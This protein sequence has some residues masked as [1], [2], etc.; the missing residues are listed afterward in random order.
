MTLIFKYACA[1]FVFAVVASALPLDRPKAEPATYKVGSIEIAQP[2][3]RATPKG[4][5]SGA[6]Y[7]TVTNTG[8]APDRMTCV[9][10]NGSAQCAVHTMSM[11]GG[12]MKMRPV[13]GGLEIAPGVSV[14]LKPSGLHMMLVDLKH[15]LEAGQTVEATLKFEHAGTI[16]VNYPILPLGAPAP[17]AGASG[18]GNIMQ[19]GGMMQMSPQH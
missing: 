1:I 11:E 12:V 13:E 15:P 10:S 16:E 4:A 9:S 3:A 14:T 6:A 8:T 7:M 2:W 18:G 5:S 19:G 17:G